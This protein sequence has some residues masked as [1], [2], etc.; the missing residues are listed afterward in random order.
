MPLREW[1]ERTVVI[2]GAARG[3]GAAL[4]RGVAARG[5]RVAGVD[6][7]AAVIETM[8]ALGPQHT[9]HVADV[10]DRAAVDALAADVT[11]AHG[12]VDALINNAGVA[13]AG[14]FED[15]PHD[16]LAWLMGV[17][18][19]G[20]V[21][22]C[23]AF[24]PH[25][26]RQPEGHVL[27]VVSSFAWLGFPGKSAYAA[28]KA[29]VRALSESLRA[30]LHGSGIGVTLLFP[31]PL[32][33]AIVREGRAVDPQKRAAEAAFLKDRAVPLEKVVARALRG[34]ERDHARVVVGSDYHL[35]DAAVR[36]SPALS[37]AAISRF[38][39]RM[40]F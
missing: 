12:R 31:G 34:I 11:S 32:D 18:F 6:R 21:H 35:I 29:A 33:T 7:D 40:P 14:R 9:A 10:A 39:K 17:N 26:R 23:R 15:V 22:G 19:W 28:S 8:R 20:V 5:A 16:D 4:A 27:N 37:L 30:E 3:L 38:A 36:V 2:T 25:L 13:V 1:N 24:L